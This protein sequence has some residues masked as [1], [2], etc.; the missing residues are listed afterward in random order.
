MD[1]QKRVDLAT[2]IFAEHGSVIRT[3]IRQHVTGADEEDEVY[4]NLYLSLVCNP[5]AQAPINVPAYLNT[6]IRNDVIDAVRRR[7]SAQQ[8]VGRYAMHQARE[9]MESPPDDVV[10][11]AE[12]VQRVTGLVG[13]LLPAREAMAVIDRYVYDYSL[14][15]I[16]L[17]MGVTPRTA[18]RYVCVGIRRVR[19][20]L[21]GRPC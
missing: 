1:T 10:T 15:D 14:T 6:I 16:A 11:Q 18:S 3:M 9:E 21:F 2:Q 20:A 7:K 4:Q 8:M 12:E 19:D 13:E 5:P 17:H